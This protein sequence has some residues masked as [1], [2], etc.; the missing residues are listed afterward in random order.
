M[1]KSISATENHTDLP[2]CI[3]SEG[4]TVHDR[5]SMLDCFNKH[6]IASGSMFSRSSPPN[7]SPVPSHVPSASDAGL[8]SSHPFCFQLF[9][10]EEVH[11]ALFSLD[12]TKSAGPDH[13]DYL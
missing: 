6:F 8:F 1:I 3:V 10:V 13:L 7:V 5:A 4:A 11:G 9:S 12:T 2:P